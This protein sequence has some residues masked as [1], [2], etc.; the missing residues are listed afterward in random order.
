MTG[1]IMV[2]EFQD[3]NRIQVN[4]HIFNHGFAPTT[5]K[6][7]EDL[8]STES[9]VKAGLKQLSDNH[10][11]YYT[12]TPLTYGLHTRLLFFRHY[13]GLKQVIENGGEIA[14]GVR[15]A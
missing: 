12:Q 15:W 13:F 7:A 10:A 2:Q 8:K 1:K 5:T 9:E 4:R 6:L 14:R 3:I 11:M